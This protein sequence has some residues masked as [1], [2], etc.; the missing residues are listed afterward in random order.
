MIIKGITPAIDIGLA[1]DT[2]SNSG[3]VSVINTN[4]A[5]TLIACGAMTVMIAA[6]ERVVVEKLPG[7]TIAAPDAASG[8]WATGVAY[9]A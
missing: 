8:V 7:D 9:K 5:A 1:P 2:V 4:N 3:L 6:G